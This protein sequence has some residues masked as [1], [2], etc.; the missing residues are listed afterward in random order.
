MWLDKYKSYDK[1]VIKRQVID[2]VMSKPRQKDD[3]GSNQ[4]QKKYIQLTA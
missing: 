3:P 4:Y 2:H 1:D